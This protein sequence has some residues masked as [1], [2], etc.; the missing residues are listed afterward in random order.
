MEKTELQ[1]EWERR[2]DI[3]KASGQSQSRW[4]KVNNLSLHQLRY[5]LKKIQHTTKSEAESSTKWI[6]VLMEEIP[7]EPTETLQIKIG[8]ASIEVKP[9][10][11]PSFLADV[12]RT[13]KT[14]C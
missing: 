13:L 7:L 6:P 3:F 9:G 8:E 14:L 2:I 11:N 12:V 10:F 4:C 1:I 5:W